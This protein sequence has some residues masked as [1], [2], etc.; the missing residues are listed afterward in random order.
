V[1]G[2]DTELTTAIISRSPTAAAL[3]R[4]SPKKLSTLCYDGRRNAERPILGGQGGRAGGES[5]GRLVAEAAREGYQHHATGS[6]VPHPF[7]GYLYR[8]LTSQGSNAP[9]GPRNYIVDGKMTGGFVLVAYPVSYRDS[10]VMRSR[11]CRTIWLV[12]CGP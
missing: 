4:V 7:H 10:G 9:G 11:A 6:R 2:F 3:R 8:M 1:R 12:T 5:L